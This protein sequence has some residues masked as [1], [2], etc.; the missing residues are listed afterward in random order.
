MEQY[1]ENSYR[2]I[3]LTESEEEKREEEE[4]TK[5]ETES[6]EKEGKEERKRKIRAVF[7]NT[8][9]T[10]RKENILSPVKY[11]LTPSL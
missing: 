10:N 6:E 11:F 3:G 8:S 1:I 5:E 2:R 7:P 9:K 4:K